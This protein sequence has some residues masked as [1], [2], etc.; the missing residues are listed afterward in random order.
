M[1]QTLRLTAL[2]EMFITDDIDIVPSV[3]IEALRSFDLDRLA[4]RR[5]QAR[6]GSG[7]AAAPA[8]PHG[9]WQL[10]GT[11]D[12]DHYRCVECHWRRGAVAVFMR[13]PELHR[14]PVFTV[15]VVRETWARRRL[16]ANST[17]RR[18]FNG[19]GGLRLL[20]AR[21][22]AGERRVSGPLSRKPATLKASPARDLFGVLIRAAALK[23]A[24]DR[25]RTTRSR[26]AARPTGRAVFAPLT[27]KA[28]R[29]QP[30]LL[31]DPR[32]TV[33]WRWPRWR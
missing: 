7:A 17:T 24:I 9:R 4:R 14:S 28:T 12:A 32:A 29:W 21:A 2:D 5:R 6:P 23:P 18:F 30:R 3:Q 25:K 27:S 26:M 13:A 20:L 11:C 33:I 22:C 16:C 8:N 1:T 15:A 19:M 31:V 10:G